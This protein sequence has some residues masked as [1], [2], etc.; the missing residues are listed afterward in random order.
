[1]GAPSNLIMKFAKMNLPSGLHLFRRVSNDSL[2]D[3]QPNL[4]EDTNYRGSMGLAKPAK[5][6]DRERFLFVSLCCNY[7]AA[8]ITIDGHRRCSLNL[9]SLKAAARVSVGREQ[10]Y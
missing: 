4:I 3:Y 9:L 2:G 8:L 6:V 1:M 10:R 5:E 7:G